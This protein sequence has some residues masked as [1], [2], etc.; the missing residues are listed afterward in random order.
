[1][2]IPLSLENFERLSF[3]QSYWLHSIKLLQPYP[4]EKGRITAPIRPF[5]STVRSAITFLFIF[6]CIKI[7]SYTYLRDRQ[8]WLV[9]FCTALMFIGTMSIFASL[10]SYPIRYRISTSDTIYK[11]FFYFATVV[12]L[13]GNIS[14]FY[15]C[16]C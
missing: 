4:K 3:S 12:T 6:Y 14:N 11:Q 10:K 5:T 15:Q 1:M 16:S 8:V 2:T 9:F 7:T 13:Q